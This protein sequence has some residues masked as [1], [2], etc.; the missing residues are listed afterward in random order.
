MKISIVVEINTIK[1][2]RCGKKKSNIRKYP[3]L[4]ISDSNECITKVLQI[5]VKKK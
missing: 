1:V 5:Y 4:A 3:T 2:Y